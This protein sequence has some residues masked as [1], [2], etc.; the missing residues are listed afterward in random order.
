MGIYLIGSLLSCFLYSV[1]L[2]TIGK[3]E[4]QSESNSLIDMFITF[5]LSWFLVSLIIAKFC[6][7]KTTTGYWFN[8]SGGKDV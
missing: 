1:Y 8:L 3:S 6:I 5:L 2:D 7:H 4:P